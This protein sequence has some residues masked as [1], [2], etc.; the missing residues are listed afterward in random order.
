VTIVVSNGVTSTYTSTNSPVSGVEI[1]DGGTMIVD[2]GGVVDA[3]Q[4]SS[5]GHDI[6]SANGT[7]SDTVISNFATENVFAGGVADFT[8]ISD[9]GSETVSSGGVASGTVISG[10][11]QEVGVV[12]GNLVNNSAGQEI[13]ASGSAINTVISGYGTQIIDGG[14]VASGTVID[15][16][17][18]FM[19]GLQNVGGT[20]ISTIVRAAGVETVDNGGVTRFSVISTGG[21]ETALFGGVAS[22]TVLSGGSAEIFGGSAFNMVIGSGGFE[23]VSSGTSTDAIVENGG[24]ELVLSGMFLDPGSA[25]GTTVLSGGYEVVSAG[26]VLSNAMVSSGGTI[27]L[28]FSSSHIVWNSAGTNVVGGATISNGAA[29]RLVLESG[30]SLSGFTASDGQW[31]AIEAGSVASGTVVGGGVSS[32]LAVANIGAEF[33]EGGI[34]SG[35]VI[36]SGGQEQVELGGSALDTVISNFG[37]ETVSAGSLASG[38][39]VKSGG[40]LFILAGGTVSGAVI[41]SGGELFN[42]SGGVVSNTTISSGGTIAGLTLTSAYGLWAAT[43]PHVIDG[44]TVEAGANIQQLFISSGGSISD[45]ID[46]SGVD[47]TVFSAGVV[48]GTTIGNGGFETVAFRG[49]ASGSMVS[50]GGYQVISSGGTA[51]DTVVSAGGSLFVSSG[52][53]ASGAIVSSGGLVSLV[54]SSSLAWNPTGTNIVDGVTISAGAIVDFT[55]GSGASLSG[56]VDSAGSVLGVR[57]EDIIGPGATTTGTVIESG[58]TEN[59]DGLAVGTVVESGGVLILENNVSYVFV[60]GGLSVMTATGVASNVVVS[61]GGELEYAGAINLLDGTVSGSVVSSGGIFED[62]QLTSGLGSWNPNVT[63]EID[64]ATIDP[65]AIAGLAI[66]GG[67]SVSG[68]VNSSGASTTVDGVANGTVVKGGFFIVDGDGV[69]SNTVVSSGGMMEIVPPGAFETGAVVSGSVVS[70]GGFVNLDAS[71]GGFSAVASGLVVSSGG[72][73]YFT[74]FGSLAWNASGANL[75]DGVTIQS[76]AHEVVTI[77]YTSGASGNGSISGFVDGPGDQLIIDPN[78]VT[79]GTVLSSGGLIDLAFESATSAAWSNNVLTLTLVSGGTTELS[80]PGSFQSADFVLSGDN[81]L[82][83]LISLGSGGAPCFCPGTLIR[84]DCGEKAVETLVAGD[85]VVT[86]MGGPGRIIWVGTRTLDCA[87]HPSP[88]TVWPVR[89]AA[90]ALGDDLPSRDLFL[91]PD[92]ALFVDDVL[93]PVK[94]LVNGTTISQQPRDQVTYYHVELARHDVILAEGLPV[95]SYLDTGNRALFANAGIATMLHPDFATVN[96]GL[97]C[98]EGNSCARLAVEADDVEP[99]WKRLAARAEALGYT[100]P[101]VSVTADPRLRL[102]VRGRELKPVTVLDGWYCFVLPQHHAGAVRMV[103]RA[104]VASAM[105]PW[106]TDLRRLGVAVRRIR[107]RCG[108]TLTEIAVDHPSLCEGWWEVERD[109]RRLWRWTNGDALLQLPSDAAMVEFQ[110]TG[111]TDYRLDDSNTERSAGPARRAVSAAPTPHCATPAVTSAAGE[112]FAITA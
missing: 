97:K 7:V 22:G 104:D 14:G 92:H 52:A 41:S 99:V 88:E 76:G 83:T 30:A 40:Q 98:R 31:V 87:R 108:A 10:A 24:E 77:A 54:L 59:D 33:V 47:D 49:L 62:F 46:G 11:T 15:S 1:L 107:V 81:D 4:V 26:G 6:V 85:E 36:S 101:T 103:S 68:F 23:A 74:E 84:T 20:A 65:G 71:F 35:S 17:T 8:V 38:T 39:Q 43:G 95:E 9:F 37:W 90:S 45:F 73:I 27:Q 111:T 109:N 5:G 94:Q 34:D 32:T 80:L 12:S 69:A 63:N 61:S 78:G 112:K 16:G 42:S 57:A 53:T 13:F 105:R 66:V 21:T 50:S 79:T 60:S 51:S 89:V 82:G 48:N 86:L 44:V 2:S 91:S 58:G 75:V 64:G 18:G 28:W 70:S 25:F 110:L 29:A 102:Q 106:L 56:F 100:R 3:A 55:L 72:T 96:A 93:I 19:E 67:G